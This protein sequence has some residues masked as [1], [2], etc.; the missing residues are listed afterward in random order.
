MIKRGYEN[1]TLYR[2]K[3]YELFVVEVST[4]K[5]KATIATFKYVK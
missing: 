3:V 4:F 1:L 5:A 2:L